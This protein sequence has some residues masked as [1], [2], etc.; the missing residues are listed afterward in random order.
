MCRN[1]INITF[2]LE[3]TVVEFDEWL[4]FFETLGKNTKSHQELPEFLKTYLHLFFCCSDY[5][6]KPY[7]SLTK[8]LLSSFQRT[9]S[10]TYY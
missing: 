9:H 5:N 7:E 1:S 8:T 6:S 4:K 2:L 10:L 3:D